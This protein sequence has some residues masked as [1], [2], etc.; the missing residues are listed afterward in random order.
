MKVGTDGVLLGA[1]CAVPETATQVLDI[2]AGTGLLSLMLAQRSEASN[3]DAV[4]IDAAAYEQCVENFEASDWGD[5]LFCYHAS[6][7]D[8]ADE[9]SEEE[10]LYDVIITNPPFYTDASPSENTARQQA[11]STQSLSF[12]NLCKGVRHILAPDGHFAVIIPAKEEVAF[13]A[14]AKQ[15]GLYPNS[16]CRVRG[17]N[18]APVKRSMLQFSFTPTEVEITALTIETARHQYTDAYIALTKDFYLNM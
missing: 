1:W 11:R 13:V 5:R 7:E 10:E 9:M 3:I 6:F 17:T 8:F 15:E 14:L 16:I 2:G 4:E 12:E 18:T